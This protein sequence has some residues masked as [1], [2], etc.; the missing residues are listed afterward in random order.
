MEKVSTVMPLAVK[1][2]DILNTLTKSGS[3]KDSAAEARASAVEAEARRKA[4]EAQRGAREQVESLR[5]AAQH[6]S[7]SA[8]VAAANSGLALSGSSL[9]SLE[10]LEHADDERVEELLGDSALRVQGILDSGAAQARSIR[11]SGRSGRSASIGL[12]GLGSL[13]SLGG[14]ALEQPWPTTVI[15]N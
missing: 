3:G 4:E 15:K 8:R 2:A 10:A 14:R 13:L 11:L 9:L 12:G 5:E 6:K 1:S 7:A